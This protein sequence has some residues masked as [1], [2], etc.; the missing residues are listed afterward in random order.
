MISKNWSTSE[1]KYDV[2]VERDVSI[3]MSDKVIIDCDI[4]RP[5]SEGKFPAILGVH[6]YDKSWQSAP[7]MPQGFATKNGSVEAGDSNFFV[8]RGYAHVIANVRGTGKSG[9]N[10]VNLGAREAEDSYEIIEWMAGQPWCDGNVGMFGV[11]NFARA[12]LQAAALNPPHLK[13]VFAPFGHTDAYRDKAYHGGILSHAFYHRWSN[14]VFRIWA[15]NRDSGKWT[16]WSKEKWGEE[17]FKE[18]IAGA[19]RDKEIQGV[20]YLVEA[21]LNPEKGANPL[22]VD[23]V[24]NKFDGE[25]FQERSLNYEN[26]RIPVFVGACW[27]NYGLHLPG[28][29]RVWEKVSSRKKMVIGPPSYLDRP[30][31]QYQYESLRW[32]DYWLKGVENDVMNEP[33]IWLFIM[34]TGEWRTASDWPLPDTRWTPFYLHSHGILSEHE[35]LPNEGCS[36][37]EDTPFNLRGGLKFLSPPVVENTEVLGPISLNLYASTTDDEILWFIS[38]LDVDPKGEEKILTRGWLRGSQRAID[39]DK[40]KPWEPFHPHAK[41]E[42]L[43]PNEIY[44]FNIG[45]VPTGNLF[46]AGHRIGLKIRCVDDEQ[47]KDF[48]GAVAQGHLWRQAP[49]YITVYHDSQHPSHLLLPIT[50]G[51]VIGTFMSGGDVQP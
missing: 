27:G 51:N 35:F 6:S 32:F 38:L 45:I 42:P 36:S 20:P 43:K 23:V 11:S 13:T 9:G 10:F 19:L 31:Y 37:F 12:A 17:K 18:L 44:Q 24:L 8:R 41:R 21:L 15:S 14:N 50:K 25:Y 49:S 40:S 3:P 28:P 22:I 34:N 26:V 33:P 39:A 1:R 7:S 30:L 46:K 29:F 48:L 16:S 47:P 4:F 5:D 2:V